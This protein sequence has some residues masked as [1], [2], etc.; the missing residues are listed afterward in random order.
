MLTIFKPYAGISPPR[1]QTDLSPRSLCSACKLSQYLLE[2]RLSTDRNINM[3]HDW[4]YCRRTRILTAVPHCTAVLPIVRHCAQQY[5][6]RSLVQHT[7]SVRWP[8]SHFRQKQIFKGFLW[9]LRHR[10]RP[11]Y[12]MG[13]A[14]ALS[15]IPSSR[16]DLSRATD[17]KKHWDF[18][19]L[20]DG[21]NDKLSVPTL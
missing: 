21:N 14:S 8:L 15:P 17:K 9:L 12:T 7:V 16:P 11:W 10:P 19:S 6:Q 1:L 4:T 13:G 20:T 2:V 5:S 3:L 18:S